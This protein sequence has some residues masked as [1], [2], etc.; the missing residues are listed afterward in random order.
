MKK[1]TALPLDIKRLRGR[2]GG[3][4]NRSLALHS[5]LSVERAK[6]LKEDDVAILIGIPS[7]Q[8]RSQIKLAEQVGQK[9]LIPSDCCKADPATG[10]C[11]G[12]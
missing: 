2:I 9:W 8:V 4:A 5:Q 11:P 1:T 12:Y 10:R 6:T 7:I 3:A